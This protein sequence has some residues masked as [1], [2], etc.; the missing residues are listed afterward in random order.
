M[1]KNKKPKLT[2]DL[3]LTQKIEEYWGEEITHVYPYTP[4]EKNEK[5]ERIFGCL[6]NNQ[7]ATLS[8]KPDGYVLVKRKESG[9]SDVLGTIKI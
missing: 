7:E 4:E 8:I 9:Y 1:T 2:S 5:G 6:D 3:K